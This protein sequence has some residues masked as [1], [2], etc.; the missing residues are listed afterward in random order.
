MPAWREVE[1][2]DQKDSESACLER[3]RKG[4]P[5]RLSDCCLERD[6]EGKDQKGSESAC[7]ERCRKERPEWL[8]KCLLREM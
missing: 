3:C 5:E 7:L 4:R 2:K 8:R 1:G 6:V